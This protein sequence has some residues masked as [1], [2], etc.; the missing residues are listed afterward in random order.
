MDTLTKLNLT[1]APACGTAPD[2]HAQARF[3]DLSVIV[4][5]LNE[6]GNVCAILGA[7][8]RSL[9]GAEIILVD[10]GSTD[11]TAARAATVAGTRV[12]REPRRGKGLAM[13]T[14]LQ[15][16]TGDFVLFHDADLEYDPIDSISVVQTVRQQPDAMVVGVRSTSFGAPPW[17]SL[18]ANALLRKV[19]GWRFGR[20]AVRGMDVLSGTRAFSRQVLLALNPDAPDFRIETHLVRRVLQQQRVVKLCPVSYLPRSRSEGKKIRPRHLFGLLNEALRR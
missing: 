3:E 13:A 18:F 4:P 16:A 8:R 19:L 12:L 15:A 17:S 6:A 2:G 5:A 1:G 10:N 11:D 9:P 14:G 20:E 7:L